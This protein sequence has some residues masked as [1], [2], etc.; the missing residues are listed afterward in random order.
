LSSSPDFARGL[1]IHHQTDLQ[2]DEGTL[3]LGMVLPATSTQF[4]SVPPKFLVAIAGIDPSQVSKNVFHINLI[5][6]L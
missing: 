2:R 6:T 3:T 4:K 5:D 1:A